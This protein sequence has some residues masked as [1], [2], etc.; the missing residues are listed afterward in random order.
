MLPSKEVLFDDLMQSAAD[1]G[2]VSRAG[3][4]GAARTQMAPANQVP[5]P[6]ENPLTPM[7]SPPRPAVFHGDLQQ[8]MEALPLP[9]TLLTDMTL[10]PDTG[11]R[12]AASFV[13]FITMLLALNPT[14]SIDL[15]SELRISM[16]FLILLKWMMTSLPN[17]PSRCLILL[18]NPRLCK[19]PL[20]PLP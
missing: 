12:S 4:K 17:S 6:P 2:Q 7:T 1:R 15:G 11:T 13:A 10:L 9:I 18:V 3:S 19:N 20:L 8:T 5:D 14:K 16:V